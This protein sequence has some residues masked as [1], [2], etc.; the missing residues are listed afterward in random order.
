VIGLHDYLIERVGIGPRRELRFSLR[1][2]MGEKYGEMR[3]AAIENYST[4]EDWWQNNEEEIDA[5]NNGRILL[6]IESTDER[7]LRS[8][9]YE[10]RIAVDHLDPL[11]VVSRRRELKS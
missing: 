2:P 4:V 1:S 9:M 6:R 3:F 10:Y 11:L 8:N 5:A 7:H